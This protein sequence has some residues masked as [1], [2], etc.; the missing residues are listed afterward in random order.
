MLSKSYE[1][2][3]YHRLLAHANCE[4]EL[5]VMDMEGQASGKYNVGA[6]EIANYGNGENVSLE[7]V[8]CNEVI[9]DIDKPLYGGE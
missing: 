9:V 7:C 2:T 3:V 6:I 5:I 4:V 1:Y 8:K